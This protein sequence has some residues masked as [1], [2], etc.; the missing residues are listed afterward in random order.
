MKEPPNEGPDDWFFDEYSQK[1]LRHSGC[2][3]WRKRLAEHR[4]YREAHPDEYDEFRARY[5]LPPRD[6]NG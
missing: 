4:A 5:G 6:A 1:W 3:H 2:A